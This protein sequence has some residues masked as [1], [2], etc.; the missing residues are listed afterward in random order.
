[1]KDVYMIKETKTGPRKGRAR[2]IRIGAAYENKDGSLNVVL[3]AL[4]L[5]GRLHIRDPNESRQGEI[6]FAGR[7]AARVVT[8]A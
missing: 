1:M 6:P 3:D 2:W 4:P 5:S 8:N 7:S